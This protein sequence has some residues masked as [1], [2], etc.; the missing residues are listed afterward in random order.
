VSGQTDSERP[1]QLGRSLRASL[2]ANDEERVPVVRADACAGLKL[3]EDRRSMLGLT[4]LTA[5]QRPKQDDCE[6][7]TASTCALP[8]VSEQLLDRAR[9]QRAEW[10]GYRVATLLKDRPCFCL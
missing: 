3:G 1:G 5:V 9:T 4:A 7:A 8:L 6:L 2:R 10:G